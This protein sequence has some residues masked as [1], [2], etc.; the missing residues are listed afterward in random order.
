MPGE[1]GREE[2]KGIHGSNGT[3]DGLSLS[4]KLLLTLKVVTEILEEYENVPKSKP[5]GCTNF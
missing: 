5:R 3:D 4:I 2:R 1:G